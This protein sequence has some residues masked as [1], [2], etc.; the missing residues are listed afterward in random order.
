MK[1]IITNESECLTKCKRLAYTNA[2]KLR[3]CYNT[4]MMHLKRSHDCKEELRNADL[5][6]TPARLAILALLERT[7]KP[8]PV[9]SIHAYLQEREIAADQA[10]VFRILNA[11]TEKGITKQVQFH[12]GKFRYELAGKE[13]HH[14]ICDSC[15]EIEDIA[16]CNIEQLEREISNKKDFLVKRHSLEFFG[17]CKNCQR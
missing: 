5:K 1:I 6:A 2:N 10:T 17:L 16:D 4:Y 11:F 7:E 12:E 8:L 13:H 3:L 9:A 14:L 15:G